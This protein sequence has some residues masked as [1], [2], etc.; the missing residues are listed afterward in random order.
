MKKTISFLMMV[1][2]ASMVAAYD[3][4]SIEEAFVDEGKISAY[5]VVADQGTAADVLAQ[6]DIINYLSRFS[7]GPATGIGKLVSE[8]DD[9]YEKDIISIGD[10][11]IS[12]I[13]KDIMDYGGDC[14]FEEGLVKFYGKK[15]K[16]QLVIYTV[17]EK[18]IRDAAASLT[19]NE[20]EGD[21]AIIKPT[22]EEIEAIKKRE[23]ESLMQRVQQ[24]TNQTQNDTPDIFNASESAEEQPAEPEPA[25]K[26][27]WT[28]IRGWFRGLF[29]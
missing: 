22:A 5:V 23:Q 15:G 27:W 1:V 3:L 6:L 8:I 13:T 21:E 14:D 11:C 9:I 7:D 24:N 17:S 29:R 19:Q 25:V 4:S 2:I 12:E 26:S 28:T 18:S 20:I 16:T 10:P